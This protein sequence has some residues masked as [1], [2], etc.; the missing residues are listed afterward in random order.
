MSRLARITIV[1]LAT[2]ILCAASSYPA[3]VFGTS[4]TEGIR[5]AEVFG[6]SSMAGVRTSVCWFDGEASFVGQTTSAEDGQWRLSVPQAGALTAVIEDAFG[7]G[8]AIRPGLLIREKGINRVN[9]G[10]PL[11]CSLISAGKPS[12]EPH[13]EYGQLIIATGT[14]FSAI[15]FRNAEGIQVDVYECVNV[16]G[17]DERPKYDAAHLGTQIG[18]RLSVSNFFPCGTLP[19]VP[20]AG[21]YL[22]FTH[23]DGKPFVMDVVQNPMRHGK[24]YIDGKL[25]QTLDLAITVQYNPSGQILRARPQ[26]P[27]VFGSAKGSYGQVF[28][29]KGSS[30]AML[31]V[32]PAGGEEGYKL[33]NIRILEGGPGGR[34]V[35]PVIKHQMFAFNPGQLPLVKGQKYCIEISPG[36]SSQDL[37]MYTEKGSLDGDP[38]Y[39][40]GKPVS[41]RRLAMSLIEYEAD[42]AG[43][44]PP[45]MIQRAP[46]DGKLKLVWDVPSDNDAV[47]LVIRRTAL[48][49]NDDSL[50]GEQVFEMPVISQGRCAWVDKDLRNGVCYRYS[51]HTV[52]LAGNESA[53][54]RGEGTPS[55]GL[56]MVV[57][58]VN[59]NFEAR[60]DFGIPYGWKPLLLAGEFPMPK[61]DNRGGN[62]QPGNTAG[63]DAN[64]KGDFIIYQQVP[65]EKGHRYRVSVDSW[66]TCPWKNENY[67]VSTLV[68]IDPLGGEDPLASSVTWSQPDYSFEQW[69]TQSTCVTS[70]SEYLTVFLRG[71]AHY[72]AAREIAVRFDNVT[73]EDI[74]HGQ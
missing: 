24:A 7:L 13:K 2:V 22:K 58:P 4:S 49:Q 67:N 21:Y 41:G 60:S 48:P 74:T 26:M 5:T 73:I 20:G 57:E 63:W 29:A 45:L 42:T 70:E 6:N 66:R 16:A 38:L 19:T 65:C 18:K 59:G 15:Q 47:K 1:G 44:A 9:I 12:P 30:L 8:P 3:E 50:E 55:A 39:I 54:A 64:G 53:P 61:V 23:K 17:K 36:A 27:Q 31:Q 37:R 11:E 71:Y 72:N 33:V 40:D 46:S 43:P 56:P 51:A 34:Q 10:L 68:G 69:H 62:A 14:S 25:D 35:G 52:D 28:T 32:F